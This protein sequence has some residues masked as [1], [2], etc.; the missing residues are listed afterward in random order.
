MPEYINIT[1]INIKE[2]D[3]IVINIIYQKISIKYVQ[4]KFYTPKEFKKKKKKIK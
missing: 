1:K 2:G 4:L 3:E